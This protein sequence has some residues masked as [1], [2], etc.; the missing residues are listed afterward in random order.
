MPALASLYEDKTGAG[1]EV[2]GQKTI[3]SLIA[4][5]ILFAFL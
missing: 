4:T 5:D 1:S 3:P 2:L